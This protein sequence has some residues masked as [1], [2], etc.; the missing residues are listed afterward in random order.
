MFRR[1]RVAFFEKSNLF[2]L[3]T[4][5]ALWYNDLRI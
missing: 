5:R 3:L 2:P 1:E 4:Q